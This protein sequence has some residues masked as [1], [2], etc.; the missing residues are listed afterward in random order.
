MKILLSLTLLLC[1]AN[2]GPV[3]YG[4]YDNTIPSYTYPFTL[5]AGDTIVATLSWPSSA[6]L[7]IYLYKQG[8]DLLSRSTWLAREYSGSLNP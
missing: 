3:N 8:Q 5:N 2:S 1:L 7:D 6:D 4:A